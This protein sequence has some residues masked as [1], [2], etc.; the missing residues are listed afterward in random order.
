VTPIINGPTLIVLS[1]PGSGDIIEEKLM[2]GKDG[3]VLRQ[4]LKD[5]GIDPEECSYALWD[6]LPELTCTLIIAMGNEAMKGLTK[7]SGIKKYRG[8]KL[9]L[10]ESYKSTCPVYPT[11]SVNDLRN[12]PTFKRT[13]IADIKNTQQ[14]NADE[15][16]FEFW[17]AD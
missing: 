13:I 5:G 12:V 16:G 8:D 3:V 1:Q 10:H 6:H 2:S 7:K 14:G 9:S 17:N 15:I 11:Y 4:L